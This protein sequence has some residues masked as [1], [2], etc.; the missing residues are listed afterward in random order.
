[1]FDIKDWVIKEPSVTDTLQGTVTLHRK[2][3]NAVL[4]TDMLEISMTGSFEGNHLKTG[5]MIRTYKNQSVRVDKGDFEFLATSRFEPFGLTSGLVEVTLLDGSKWIFDGEF[6][7]TNKTFK[8]FSGSVHHETL[9]VKKVYQGV[10]LYQS[11]TLFLKCFQYSNISLRDLSYFQPSPADQSEV[12][13]E[14][15][16][17]SFVGE[18]LHGAGARTQ[19]TNDEQPLIENNSKGVFVHGHFR[20]GQ[21]KKEDFSR[22]Q[23]TI[24]RGE[25]KQGRLHTQK[26]RGTRKLVDSY[27]GAVVMEDRGSFDNGSFVRGISQGCPDDE[28]VIY[29][30]GALHKDKYDDPNGILLSFSE[31]EGGRL[32]I[33]FSAGRTLNGRSDLG[34][35]E[36]FVHWFKIQLEDTYLHGVECWREDGSA[37]GKPVW[38][39]KCLADGTFQESIY[40]TNGLKN[41]DKVDLNKVNAF[42]LI[43]GFLI[44][45]GLAFVSI[46]ESLAVLE[47]LN[48]PRDK[49]RATSKIN[50]SEISQLLKD[51]CREKQLQNDLRAAK[52]IAVQEK[53]KQDAA[54]K[55]QK[56]LDKLARQAERKRL[57]TEKKEEELRIA[58]EKAASRQVRREQ[59][60]SSM[61]SNTVVQESA[62]GAEVT[63]SSDLPSEA[64]ATTTTL[65]SEVLLYTPVKAASSRAE[66]NGSDTGLSN[67]PDSKRDEA[68]MSPDQDSPGECSLRFNFSG[69]NL[70]K[71]QRRGG[72]FDNLSLSQSVPPSND[73]EMTIQ[74]SECG[75]TIKTLEGQSLDPTK[76]S[77]YKGA[78]SPI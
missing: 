30:C 74:V 64:S 77:P 61:W 76:D 69:K 1:M 36:H 38:V 31:S 63:G 44:E 65:C 47:R 23:H 16:E 11:E 19:V 9:S 67:S 35:S 55:K 78:P 72:F 8:T 60:I 37:K 42:T 51:E 41:R 56:E 45:C 57:E 33:G 46:S 34:T 62:S 25:F 39:L 28:R 6:N 59:N 50:A 18:N 27:T 3:E 29:Y 66:N 40:S 20:Q 2:F 71:L 32:F 75:Q 17:G 49:I 21:R 5:K 10:F 48:P 12:L 13:V 14:K 52:K 22:N 73:N 43:E 7:R 26:Y 68:V 70:K 53:A 54:L 4:D 58:R 24:D 15:N